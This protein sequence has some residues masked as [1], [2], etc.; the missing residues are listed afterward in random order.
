MA[1]SIGTRLR[2]IRRRQRLSQFEVAVAAGLR[3]D[4]VSLLERGCYVTDAELSALAGALGVSRETLTDSVCDAATEERF[5]I[6]RQ[7][8]VVESSVGDSDEADEAFR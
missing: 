6:Q 3:P 7:R 4:K 5:G 2:D 1:L 8:S